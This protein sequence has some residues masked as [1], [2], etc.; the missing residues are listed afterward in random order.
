MKTKNISNGFTL[1]ELILV[2]AIIG[3]L[4]AISIPALNRLVNRSKQIPSIKDINAP[5]YDIKIIKI[6]GCEYL[7]CNHFINSSGSTIIHKG[8]C[9]NLVHIPKEK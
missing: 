6:D 2:I 4:L 8:D 5:T 9:S 1:V 3:V 7:V